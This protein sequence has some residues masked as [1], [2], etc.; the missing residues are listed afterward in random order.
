MTK[1]QTVSNLKEKTLST[2]KS[3]KELN[4]NASNKNIKN[5]NL[6]HLNLTAES[7]KKPEPKSPRTLKRNLTTKT[8]NKTPSKV[9]NKPIANTDKKESI[10]F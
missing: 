5:K 10:N 2:N 8:L 6:N 1:N 9:M 7:E 3:T 4:R